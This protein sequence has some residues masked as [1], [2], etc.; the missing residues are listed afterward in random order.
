MLTVDPSARITFDQVVSHPWVHGHVL[1]DVELFLEMQQR[2]AHMRM[3]DRK[4]VEWHQHQFQQF[5]Q[6]TNAVSMMP[7]MV[8]RPRPT[9]IT[10]PPT[11]SCTPHPSPRPPDPAPTSG[12][13][14]NHLVPKRSAL[15]SQ[16]VAALANDESEHSAASGATTS[17]SGSERSISEKA[18]LPVAQS[19]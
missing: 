2:W 12:G 18:A 4:A 17:E 5:Q 13:D 6:F 3:G 8:T 1:T 10:P 14:H 19:S 15:L 7:A 11:N 9:M 16:A